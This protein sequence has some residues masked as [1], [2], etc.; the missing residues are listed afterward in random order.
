MSFSN[1]RF[2]NTRAIRKNHSQAFEEEKLPG[3][4]A[5]QFY[6]VHIGETFNSK[7]K[8]LG[9]LGYGAYSTVWLCRDTKES[10]YVALKVCT[11]DEI[12][13]LRYH[14]ELKFY[15][16]VSSLNWQ[17]R[18]QAYI[19]GLLEAF[20]INGPA[21]KHLCLVQPPMHMSIQELQRQNPS[22]RL[23]K[24]ILNWTLVNLFHALTFLHDEAQ[25]VHT[26]INPSNIMLS[27][28]DESLLPQFEQAEAENPSP[29]KVIDETRTIYGSRKLG[30][31]KGLLWGQR[32]LCDFGEARTGQSH[33]GLIQPELYRAPE[34]LFNMEW[35]YSVDIWNVAVLIWDLFEGRHLFHALDEAQDV[36]ATDHVAEMVGY[37]GV[38]PLEYLRHSKVTNNVFDEKGH[39]K[40]AGGVAVPEMTVEQAEIVLEG[41]EKKR[42]LM[43]T[44]G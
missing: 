17:H 44:H 12:D 11:R 43:F 42:F 38:P 35:S 24:P 21:V 5:D 18:G 1:P 33:K 19:R 39:W 2:S 29:R 20:E 31:P 7:Y 22:K 14:R 9:K 36:S 41:E 8:V 30:L 26:D 27:I 37:L 16:H 6:S 32:V 3:Y 13:S 34:V 15:E 25:V 28:D 10:G 23:N 4:H 40:S